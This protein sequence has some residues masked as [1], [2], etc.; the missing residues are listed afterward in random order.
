MRITGLESSQGRQE[1]VCKGPEA[2]E[3]VCP[4]IKRKANL[5]SESKGELGWPKLK[6]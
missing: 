6:R 4:E 1:S 3:M 5:G 2:E